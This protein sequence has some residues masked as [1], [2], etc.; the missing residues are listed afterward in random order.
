LQADGLHR[1]EEEEE[2]R[3][4]DC[5]AGLTV[6]SGFLIIALAS[7]LAA[8]VFP[9]RSVFFDGE[10]LLSAARCIACSHSPT[11]I[12]SAYSLIRSSSQGLINK[13]KNLA[14]GGE[15][16]ELTQPRRPCHPRVADLSTPD[17]KNVLRSLY[18][19]GSLD[20]SLRKLGLKSSSLRLAFPMTS[21]IVVR[22]VL[23]FSNPPGTS[24]EASANERSQL[25]STCM[26]R[27]KDASTWG[28]NRSAD[29]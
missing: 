19:Y 14:E 11:G 22:H 3:S 23:S 10:C 12:I 13:K 8:Q 2:K 6:D 27:L 26:H 1:E 28:S 4:S 7:L 9:F 15:S 5:V 21:F 20:L 18:T 25:E 29:N 24:Y 17:Q 16:R